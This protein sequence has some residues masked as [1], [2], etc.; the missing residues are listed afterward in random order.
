MAPAGC[1]KRQDAFKGE[2]IADLYRKAERS[3]HLE[4]ELQIANEDVEYKER[5]VRRMEGERDSAR[6]A[7]IDREAVEAQLKRQIEVL[8][9]HLEKAS[10]NAIAKGT[11]EEHPSAVIEHK[12][13]SF[14]TVSA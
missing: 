3:A 1:L 7:L 13:R 10:K 4:R 14:G 9:A 6:A 5:E 12:V 2:S 11:D 8:N